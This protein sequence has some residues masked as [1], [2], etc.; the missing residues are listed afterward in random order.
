MIFLGRYTSSA[1]HRFIVF[2]EESMEGG[3]DFHMTISSMGWK[4]AAVAMP[5]TS[6]FMNENNDLY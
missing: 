5:V 4:V 2:H 6:G 3:A 1:V